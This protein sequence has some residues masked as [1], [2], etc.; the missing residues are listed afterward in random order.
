MLDATTPQRSPLVRGPERWVAGVC[1][2][3]AIHLNIDV[4]MVRWAMA[5]LTLAGGAGVLLYAW[6]WI[7]VPRAGETDRARS[8]SE[9][10][11]RSVSSAVLRNEQLDRGAAEE[12]ARLNRGIAGREFLLGAILLIG[13]GLIAA[14]L[15]GF[16]VDWRL[17]LPGAA[18]LVGAVTAWM[19][20]DADRR[21][22]LRKDVGAERWVGA[23]RLMVGLVLVIGGALALLTGVVPVESL[24]SGGVIALAIIAGIVLVLLPWGLREWRRF[25]AERSAGWRAAE[26]AEIA[27]HLHDSV[28]QTLALIQRLADDPLMVARLARSQER[29]LREWLY[30][31]GDEAPGDLFATIKREAGRIEDDFGGDIDVVT[32]GNS[33]GEFPTADA[34]LQ[35]A[36]E[37]MLNAVKHGGGAVTV[38][39]EASQDSVEVFVRDHGPGF[40]VADI[41]EDRRGLR[42]SIVGRMER[43]GGTARV[44]SSPDGTEI[45]LRLPITHEAPRTSEEQDMP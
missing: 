5:A 12:P 11:Q 36:R 32:V 43:N 13:A 22:G 18:I 10:G 4:R 1:T 38:Y 29:E 30:G 44:S 15:F 17:I 41:P 2:G 21:E 33:P 16:A 34:L 26:R 20:L 19:Q 7:F 9:A 24:L 3:V 6:L 35:A 8:I 23:T 25:V 28:L 40:D 14:S 39:C 37:A 45:A 31:R 42:D 27:A